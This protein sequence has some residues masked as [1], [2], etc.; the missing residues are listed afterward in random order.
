MCGGRVL[1]AAAGRGDLVLPL[2]PLLP[3]HPPTPHP[4]HG[5]LAAL[6][7]TSWPAWSCADVATVQNPDWRRRAQRNQ[8]VVPLV[9]LAKKGVPAV[10]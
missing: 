7:P 8:W 3:A 10:R 6:A 9:S 2:L 1:V 4:S 5:G